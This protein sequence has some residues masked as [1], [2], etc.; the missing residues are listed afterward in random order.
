L[1]EDINWAPIKD[2]FKPNCNVKLSAKKKKERRKHGM[3]DTSM[4]N[5]G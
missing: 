5:M 4:K 2:L 1:I 3:C